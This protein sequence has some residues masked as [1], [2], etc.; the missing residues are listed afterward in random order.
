MISNLGEELVSPDQIGFTALTQSDIYGGES[1]QE[2]AKI[3]ES[4]LK[5]NGTQAQNQ[6]VTANAGMAMYCANQKEGKRNAIARA[7]E[8]LESGK[9]LEAFKRLTNNKTQ[10]SVN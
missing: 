3:F 9:A 6:V 5:G 2:S 10:I 7:K 8:S 4:V 1:V